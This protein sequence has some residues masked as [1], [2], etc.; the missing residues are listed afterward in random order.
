VAVCVASEATLFE[1]GPPE[2][3][4]KGQVFARSHEPGKAG[5]VDGV[6]C[7]HGLVLHRSKNLVQKVGFLTDDVFRWLHVLRAIQLVE[8]YGHRLVLLSCSPLNVKGRLFGIDGV[9]AE[10]ALLSKWW[11]IDEV[12]T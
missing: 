12:H 9:A 1:D 8:R 5:C 11:R 6:L 3:I 10:I 4:G 2:H 7:K